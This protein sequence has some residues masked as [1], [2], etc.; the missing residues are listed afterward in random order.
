LFDDPAR[1]LLTLLYQRQ[2]CSMVVLGDLL[3]TTAACIGD[4]VKETRR[5]L[6]DHGHLPSTAPVRFKTARDLLAFLDHDTVPTR[7][8]IIEKLSAPTLTGMPRTELDDLV[9]RLAARQ[10]AQA[11]RLAHQR[12]GGARQPGARGGVFPQKIGNSE[13]V[14]LTLVY[15]RRLCNLDVLA[16]ALGDVSRSAIGG[17]V[18]ETRPLIEQEGCMPPPS[19]T[20]YRTAAEL[21][22]AA[23]QD[24]DTP[25]T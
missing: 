14:L 22:A 19:L 17:V 25:T 20:R 13:R 15:L 24:H 11:E 23:D 3:E 18:R 16:E 2:V 7:T 21:L 5:V 10:A 12:R 6:E 8:A 1:V 9:R 4:L